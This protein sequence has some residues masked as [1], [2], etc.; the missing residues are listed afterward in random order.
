[1]PRPTSTE[2]RLS[3][4]AAANTSWAYTQD[5]AARTAPARA[6]AAARFEH[7]VDPGGVL[8]PDERA[9][10]AES[11]RKAHFQLLALKSAQSRRHAKEAAEQAEA[12]DAELDALRAADPQGLK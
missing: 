11:L 12:A 1:M 4:Q 8:A 3:A 7:L 6:A 9:R 2:R 10:R 5:R